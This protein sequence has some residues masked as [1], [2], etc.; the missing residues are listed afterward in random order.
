MKYLPAR[1]NPFFSPPAMSYTPMATAPSSFQARNPIGDPLWDYSEPSEAS[2][3]KFHSG[4]VVTWSDEAV[5]W[6]DAPAGQRLTVA[7]PSLHDPQATIVAWPS[8]RTRE[9]LN[10]DLKLVSRARLAN[11]KPFWEPNYTFAY[12]PAYKPVQYPQYKFGSMPPTANVQAGYR[13]PMSNPYHQELGWAE[14]EEI[15][16]WEEDQRRRAAMS[17]SLAT[18]GSYQ[19]N[20]YHPDLG[21]AEQDEIEEWEEDQARR[22]AMSGSL[23][24]LGSYQFNP[25]AKKKARRRTF[26]KEWREKRF[27]WKRPPAGWGVKL[28]SK[29]TIP[30]GVKSAPHTS[31]LWKA[32][33]KQ[34]KSLKKAEQVF[35]AKLR[36]AWIRNSIARKLPKP[37]AAKR[38]P[39]TRKKPAR[40]K[41]PRK[42]AKK[43]APRKKAPRK[44]AKKRRN[45]R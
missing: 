18:L 28:Y 42:K 4:D 26:S 40:K 19:L 27:S 12:E 37:V 6:G 39:K 23:A 43:K 7:Y 9:V 1:S 10:R 3:H 5:E 22:A 35:Y 11:P 17:G 38:N 25:R 24:T 44:K 30:R 41:A 20:P 31:T 36:S 29:G 2:F 21:W 45:A 34:Y 14:Q 16:E 13:G 33:R 15:E 32:I 8:G